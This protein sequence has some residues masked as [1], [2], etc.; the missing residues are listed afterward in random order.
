MSGAVAATGDPRSRY[1][2][3]ASFHT[4]LA[5]TGNGAVIDKLPGL[6]RGEGKAATCVL[7]Y[8]PVGSCPV[9]IDDNVVLRAFSIHQVDLNGLALMHLE[10]GIDLAVD[11]ATRAKENHTAFRDAGSQ[12][13]DLRCMHVSVGRSCRRGFIAMLL[14]ER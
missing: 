12:R 7:A 1:H 6:G 11:V 10:R 4:G 3:N 14:C 2:P 13:E 9:L 5:M 8:N